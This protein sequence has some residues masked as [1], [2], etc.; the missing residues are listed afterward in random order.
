MASKYLPVK[1]PTKSFWHSEADDFARHRTTT[2]LPE[3]ADVVIIGSGYAGASTAY[4][5]LKDNPSKPSIVM[6]EARD[7]CSGAT[8]R[9]GGHLKPDIYHS[10][11]RFTKEYGEKKCAE[12]ANFEYEHLAAFKELIEEENIDC[13]FVLTR[14]MDIH[15]SPA[16]NKKCLENYEAMKQNPYILCKNDIMLYEGQAARTVSKNEKTQIAVSYTAGQLWPYKMVIGLL[17]ILIKKHGMNLQ[18]NTPALSIQRL[19][20][21]WLVTT[22]RGTIN[23]EILVLATNAYTASIEPAMENKIVPIK[24]ICSH[25]IKTD[26]DKPVPYLTNTYGIRI[27]DQGDVDYLINRLDG[28]VIVGG[29]KKYIL[30]FKDRFY[31]IVDDSTLIENTDRYFQENYMARHFSTWKDFASRPDYVWAGILGYTLDSL[32]YVGELRK[33]EFIIAGFHGH[34]MPRALLSAKALAKSIRTGAP[35]SDIPDAFKVTRERLSAENTILK[36]FRHVKL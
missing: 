5:L 4:Y 14:A 12:I 1:N 32:P 10:N 18:T 20:N 23:C 34:G 3:K 15:L 36:N 2:T 7:T 29:A 28:S 27:S 8:G 16:S 26:A 9:N 22:A 25:I 6:L 31:N 11:I 33:N 13:D 19:K 24:G 21:S 30:P 17:K 35:L